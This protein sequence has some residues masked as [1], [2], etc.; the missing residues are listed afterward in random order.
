MKEHYTVCQH[1][2]PFVLNGWPY[3]VFLVFLNTL[4]M[5]LRSLVAWIPSSA[6]L[7]CPRKQLPSAFWQADNICLNFFGLFGE[8]VCIHCFDCSLIAT[9]TNETQ[10]SSSVTHMIWLR[11]SSPS[12]WYRSK[13]VKARVIRSVLCA[14][15]SIHKTHLARNLWSPLCFMCTYE[16]SQN[17]S[18]TKPVIAS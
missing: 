17:P 13:K 15:M 7:S 9:F 5:L 2:T 12:L 1:S 18:C 3:A 4:L 6:L 16:Y 14:P 11:N 8:C 10:A